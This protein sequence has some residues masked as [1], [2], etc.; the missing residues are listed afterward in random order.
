MGSVLGRLLTVVAVLA[1][2]A[3]CE[4]RH[5]AV[6]G[7]AFGEGT[8][9][10][11]EV[12]QDQL[13]RR[14]TDGSP[15]VRPPSQEPAEEG[16]PG[17][18]TLATRLTRVPGLVGVVGHADSRGS[19]FAAPVY[20][21]AHIPLVVPTSTSR[22]L[23]TVSPWVF[24]MSPDDSLEADFIAAFARESLH[25]RSFAIFYDSDEYGI[26]LRDGLRTAFA[27]LGLGPRVE[28]PIALPCG[29]P[30]TAE[31]SILR[32]TARPID[33]VVIAGRTRDAACLGRRLSERVRGLRIIGGDAVEFDS[34]FERRFGSARA[35]FYAVAVWH[36]GVTDSASVD[37]ARA[38]R[39]IVGTSP[40]S[41]EALVFDA[42]ML[43]AEATRAVGTR[44][45]AVRRY[46]AELGGRRPPYQGVTGAVAF[47]SG[48]PR[49]LYMLR[50]DKAVP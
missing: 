7:V 38:Y 30:E 13:R 34:M 1:G 44:P 26:G 49:P 11:V 46:L 3:S 32:A 6:I 2:A 9:G 19:L 10:V 18:V 42:V 23:R 25:T 45:A 15:T 36:A 29:S 24:M 27:A 12:V 17:A 28:E 35:P 4:R 48:A 40:H 21:E 50:I 22:R 41:S 31:A 43:L 14:Y 5:P 33:L 16:A 47:G 8:P 37:F 20:D 39:G